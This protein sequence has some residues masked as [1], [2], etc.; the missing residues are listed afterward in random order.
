[1]LRDEFPY[2][3]I[4]PGDLADLPSLVKAMEVAQ[5]DEIYNLAAISFTPKELGEAIEKAIPGFEMDYSPDFRQKIADSWPGSIDDS[6]AR[7]DWGWN[8]QFGMDELVHVMLDGLKSGYLS[9]LGPSE[10]CGPFISQKRVGELS[11][12]GRLPKVSFPWMNIWEKRFPL[13]IRVE[14]FVK[15]AAFFI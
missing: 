13:N 15:I 5:P 3:N 11:I 12:F 7:K 9:W 14:F 4:V 6:E 10:K 1:M 8:H 2:V